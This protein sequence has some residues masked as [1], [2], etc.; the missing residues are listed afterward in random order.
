MSEEVITTNDELESLKQ[1]ADLL[2][3]NYHPSIGL[4]KLRD[5]VNAAVVEETPKE[6]PK[7]VKLS[8]GALRAIKKKEAGK[9][10]RIRMTC[11]N[12][13]KSE[14]EG[15]LFTAGNSVV[16]SYTRMVPFG[17][18]WHVPQIMLNMIQARRYQRFYTERAKNGIQVPRS[19]LSKEFAVEILPQLSENE[20]SDLAQRQ[21]MANGTSEG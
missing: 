13:A 1:R 2:G 19:A 14:W 12:P 21:A 4:D 7:E 18:E 11:M 20:L 17:V 9:L 3:L 16:G 5:K 10:I 6:Q 8:E 15:E